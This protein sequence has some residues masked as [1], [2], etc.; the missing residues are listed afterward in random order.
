MARDII[1]PMVLISILSAYGCT[2]SPMPVPE[3][4]TQYTKNNQ[5]D[6]PSNHENEK[7]KKQSWSGRPKTEPPTHITNDTNPTKILR[8]EEK[9]RIKLTVI[10]D[11]SH[12]PPSNTQPTTRRSQLPNE[13]STQSNNELDS[14][15]D[16]VDRI[17]KRIGKCIFEGSVERD[18]FAQPKEEDTG[19]AEDRRLGTTKPK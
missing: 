12:S 1:I 5:L 11:T 19:S 16:I 3:A 6:H 15:K 10:G 9:S 13:S 18:T 2:S 4:T 14:I 17:Q 7:A 8:L